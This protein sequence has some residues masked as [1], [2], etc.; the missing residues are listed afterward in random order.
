M[1]RRA[2][3]PTLA[4]AKSKDGS[5]VEPAKF[6]PWVLLMFLASI[7]ATVMDHELVQVVVAG[8]TTPTNDVVLI[9]GI[10]AIG[11]LMET[12][13]TA[14]LRIAAAPATSRIQAVNDARGTVGLVARV[15]GACTLWGTLLGVPLSIDQSEASALT[16]LG[17]MSTLGFLLGV[18]VCV[19][20]TQTRW[21]RDIRELWRSP[22]HLT[23]AVVV[24]ALV[25]TSMYGY[26]VPLLSAMR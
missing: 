26:V 6:F 9:V 12:L 19:P 10:L 18:I 7:P 22:V 8:P 13:V 11:L 25:S 24:A 23:G 3:P 17:S 2:R 16:V 14:E 20:I 5:A 21:V 4:S 1:A 15:T